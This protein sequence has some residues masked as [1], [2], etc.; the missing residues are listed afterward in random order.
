MYPTWLKYYAI[1]SITGLAEFDKEKHEFK[2][3][4]KNTR[5]VFPDLNREALA[6][7][8]DA[9]EKKHRKQTKEEEKREEDE[10]KTSL[11]SKVFSPKPKPARTR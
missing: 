1:R 6:Y 11:F 10:I 7:V 2:K 4:S 9:I 8:L 3:R 5:S